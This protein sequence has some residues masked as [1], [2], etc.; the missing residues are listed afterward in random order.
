MIVSSTIW[1]TSTLVTVEEVEPGKS[2]TE[3]TTDSILLLEGTGAT[4]TGLEEA[5]WII[6]DDVSAPDCALLAGG[7]GAAIWE[8]TSDC[9]PLAD[10]IS[11]C[12]R[13]N[14]NI[15]TPMQ[16][17]KVRGHG[18][19]KNHRNNMLKGCCKRRPSALQEVTKLIDL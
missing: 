3:T 15:I 13:A 11:T 5:P 14:L 8:E 6:V 10:A 2:D 17:E 9:G 16:K 19:D 18:H 1:T 4:G 12:S 7:K